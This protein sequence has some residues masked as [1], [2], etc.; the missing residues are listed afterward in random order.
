MRGDAGVDHRDSDAIAPWPGP[1]IGH[2]RGSVTD[3]DPVGVPQIPL[4]GRVPGVRRHTHRLDRHRVLLRVCGEKEL[5]RLRPHHLIIGSQLLGHL[6][7]R[8]QI[9]RLRQLHQH[10]VLGHL[11]RHREVHSRQV[12]GVLQA[13]L[14]RHHRLALF[15]VSGELH[16]QARDHAFDTRRRSRRHDLRSLG[17]AIRCDREDL[18]RIAHPISQTQ[19]CDVS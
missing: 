14:P 11:L 3:T 15:H 13:L 18:E 9:H 6:L 17:S 8:G 7:C 2:A 19:N 1:R 12:R 4:V 10:R 16:D 5:I